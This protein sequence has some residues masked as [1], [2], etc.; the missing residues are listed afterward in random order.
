MTHT[1][2]PKQITTILNSLDA[3]KTDA[4]SI[5]LETYIAEL[6]ARQP[7]RPT[8]ITSI[9]SDIDSQ[10]P[11]D[12]VFALETYIANL[13]SNQQVTKRKQKN[14]PVLEGEPAPIWS[15]KRAEQRRQRRHRRAT[16]KQTS[17]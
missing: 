9:L 2:R 15:H 10:Y 11:A 6:E 5:E 4:G 7:T 17:S 16:L 12:I 14:A 1:T 3:A 8:H 13:E